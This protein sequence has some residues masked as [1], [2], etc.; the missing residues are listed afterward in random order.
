MILGL[1]F[2]SDNGFAVSAAGRTV[3]RE[4]EA[5]L[6]AGYA[7]LF[8]REGIRIDAGDPAALVLF[9][10]MDAALDVPQRPG[11]ES[12]REGAHASGD[13]DSIES[14]GAEGLAPFRSRT[15]SSCQQDSSA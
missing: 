7:R 13:R 15:R 2:L 10:E 11:R 12:E 4:S 1:K 8:D 14:S 9:P 6:R 5:E 3:W